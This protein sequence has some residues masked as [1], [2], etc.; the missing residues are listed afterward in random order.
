MLS[1]DVRW[2]VVVV[3]LPPEELNVTRR[4]DTRTMTRS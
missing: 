1:P 3:S 4:N 2:Q